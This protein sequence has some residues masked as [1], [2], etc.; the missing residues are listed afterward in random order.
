MRRN[1]ALLRSTAKDLRAAMEARS[2]SR[3]KRLTFPYVKRG[4]DTRGPLMEAVRQMRD[5]LLEG[6]GGAEEEMQCIQEALKC[7]AANAQ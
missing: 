4:A 3:L 7:V 2:A 5:E 6:T 1:V